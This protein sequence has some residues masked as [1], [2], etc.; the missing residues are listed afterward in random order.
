MI[1][2]AAVY[3][4]V[5]PT[6]SQCVEGELQRS[7]AGIQYKLLTYSD[8]T[9]LDC[10]IQGGGSEKKAFRRMIDMYW[11]AVGAD[12]DIILNVCSSV[13]DIADAAWPLLNLIG[14]P[15]IRIDEDMAREAVEHYKHIGVLATLPST[16]APTRLLLERCS[17]EAE[18]SVNI[19]AELCDG[20]FGK[21]G[22]ALATELIASAK[23]LPS[24]IELIILAQ[25]SMA[26]CSLQIE[27]ATGIKTLSSPAFG[28]RSVERIASEII[29]ERELRQ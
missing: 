24:D 14:V 5:T 19:V 6:L 15:L 3:T 23:K 4:V 7:L 2:I 20:G 17:K 27:E 25:A 12:V 26:G 9:A 21:S 18:K 1:K 13:G 16:L 10:M 11:N 8:P 29:K 28:A 22:S